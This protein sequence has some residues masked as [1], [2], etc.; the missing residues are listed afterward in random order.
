[1]RKVLDLGELHKQLRQ[2]EEHEPHFDEEL[3]PYLLDTVLPQL[4]GEEPIRLEQIDFDQFDEEDPFT[5]LD[6][7]YW[8]ENLCNTMRHINRRISDILA[9]LC[10]N[11]SV[12][13]GGRTWTKIL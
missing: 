9:V 4:E 6:Y 12:F 10:E 3:N 1:M 2:T 8:R 7:Y 13:I 5:I 11:Q